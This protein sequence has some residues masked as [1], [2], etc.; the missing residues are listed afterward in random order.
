MKSLKRFI[1]NWKIP[2]IL[3]IA[4]FL[5]VSSLP[6]EY[7]PAFMPDSIQNMKINL[8][9]D[10]QGGSQLDYRIDLSKVAEEDEGQIVEG[11]LE[12][13]NERVNKLGVSEPNIYLSNVGDERHIIVE[14][15][16][17]K[18]LDEAKAQVGKTIQL[19]FKTEN[20]ST[21]NDN[22]EQV[23]SEAD[24]FVVELSN[25]EDFSQLAEL[26]SKADP[27]NVIYDNFDTPLFA[28]QIAGESLVEKLNGLEVG[29]YTETYFEDALG[30]SVV[31]ERIVQ[32][33]GYTFAKLNSKEELERDKVTPRE[34]VMETILVGYDGAKESESELTKEESGFEASKIL[35]SIVNQEQ[36]FESFASDYELNAEKLNES[37]NL[38]QIKPELTEVGQLYEVP[39]ETEYGFAIVR[40]KEIKEEASETV[41]ETAYTF[42]T[43]V[44]STLPDPWVAT[45]L[46]GSHFERADLSFYNGVTPVVA[47][48]FNAEGAKLFEEITEDNIGKRVAI[49]VGGNLVS[50][51]TVNAKISGG[52]AII[53]GSFDLEGA[54]EL[55]RDL[56][57]GAIPAPIILAG[58]YSIG[59]NLGHAA[60]VSSLKAAALGLVMLA[61]Y[62][63]AYYRFS[64]VL[65]NVALIV[66]ST[67]LIFLIKSSLPM[68]LALI[69]A[70]VIYCGTLAKIYSS[71]EKLVEKTLSFVVA[72][73]ALFFLSFLL[74]SPVVLTLAG[75]AGIVL[76]VGM[77]VDA[78]VLIFE[79]IKEEVRAGKSYI[80]AVEEGFDKAWS[81]I[82]DSNFSSLITCGILYFFGSSIIR[83]F[84]LNL[85]AGILISMFTAITVTRGMLVLADKVPN[86]NMRLLFGAGKGDKERKTIDFISKSKVWFAISAVLVVVSVGSIATKGLNAGIDFTGGTLMEVQIPEAELDT[87]DKVAEIVEGAVGSEDVS[88]VSS[89][90]NSFLIKTKYI[91]EGTHEVI[92]Q[93]LMNDFGSEIE[94]SRFTTVG[95]TISDSLKTKAVVALVIALI[96]I[97]IY[98]ALTFRNIPKGYSPWKF[99]LSAMVALTH[100]VIITLG[101]FSIFGLQ[102]DALFITALLTVIGFS[103]HDTIV[104]FDRVRENL[105]GSV[106][107]KGQFAKICNESLTQTLARSIN[108]SI[109]TLL[110]LVALLILGSPSIFEFVLALVIGI[111]I[112]TYSSIFIASPTLNRFQ[113]K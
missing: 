45:E 103:V 63:M 19:E 53:S 82:R 7:Q 102:V 87:K 50:S 24:E 5:G 85:A 40:A 65:A 11:I 106:V 15:A 109:S 86:K 46:N 3:L 92:L 80:K 107:K 101:V 64:G 73:F 43:L 49:F 83:G 90:D 95:P 113:R 44:F 69:F 59:P 62:M 14:L 22:L 71:E 13:I 30:Y 55:A 84:A 100:D 61:L 93:R 68:W 60:L 57:T 17:V 76:S 94:E 108:T 97:I 18:D 39:V 16:G 99:G 81:S 27:A 56:N 104:V 26:A 111:G 31:S 89:G 58:Q 105:K 52:E 2:M 29:S 51:P 10:L 38:E 6:S 79:R 78:N 28:D 98:I 12:V 36:T 32:K 41:V 1:G 91:Q 23:K 47:V 77:A 35:S 110:T 96:A 70:F 42:E 74:S 66:Y 4:V 67:L 25:G 48:K 54:Q 37:I 88:V 34:V 8:G 20:E 75:V 9:L 21:E 112:G 33:E 72:T